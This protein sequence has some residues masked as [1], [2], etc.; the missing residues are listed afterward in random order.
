M[1]LGARR[2]ALIALVAF[3]AAFGGVVA[4]RMLLPQNTPS[5]Y[6]HGLLHSGLDL[7]PA[8][9]ATVNRIEADF[10]PRHEALHAEMRHDNALIAKAFVEERGYGPRV[11][12]A[13]DRSHAA[14]GK[15]QKATFEQL[16]AV[17]RVLRPDQAARFDRAVVRALSA[18][19]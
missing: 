14:M 11:E 10:A 1:K 13:V 17:R 18:K 12:E 16:F 15:M 4:G 2:I 6:I 9:L 8:Q 7:D 19:R 3:I 5:S